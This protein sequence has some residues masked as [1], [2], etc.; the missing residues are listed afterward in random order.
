MCCLMYLMVYIEHLQTWSFSEPICGCTLVI[1][2]LRTTVQRLGNRKNFLHLLTKH[3]TTKL[4]PQ[5][6][7]K[8]SRQIILD[9]PSSF[10]LP[11]L[12]NNM[13]S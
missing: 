11:Q 13:T 6:Q 9:G 3:D 1:S 10:L 5:L 8:D 7:T 12:E 2:K 4:E